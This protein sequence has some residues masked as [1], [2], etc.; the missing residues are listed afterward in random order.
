MGLWQNLYQIGNKKCCT[1]RFIKI[2]CRKGISMLTGLKV[3]SFACKCVFHRPENYAM[4]E[5]EWN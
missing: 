4:E 5:T 3:L 2:L 1:P